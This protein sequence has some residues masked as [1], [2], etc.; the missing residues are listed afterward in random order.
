MKYF[1]IQQIN[2]GNLIWG[3]QENFLDA[4][5]PHYILFNYHYFVTSFT[6]L[7]FLIECVQIIL[8]FT[9]P[10]FMRDWSRDSLFSSGLRKLGI[11]TYSLWFCQASSFLYSWSIATFEN[12]NFTVQATKAVEKNSSF[13]QKSYILKWFFH[14]FTSKTNSK[15]EFLYFVV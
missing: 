14:I 5:F 15:L 3:I 11:A 10:H 6:M 4:G 13:L 1:D 12:M 7:V 2:T 9:C 8:L